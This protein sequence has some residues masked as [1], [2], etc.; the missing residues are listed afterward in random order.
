MTPEAFD[1][2]KP[3]ILPVIQ[4]YVAARVNE[5]VHHLTMKDLIHILLGDYDFS[6]IKYLLRPLRL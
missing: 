6:D 1:L 2:M 5:T 3:D 4:D